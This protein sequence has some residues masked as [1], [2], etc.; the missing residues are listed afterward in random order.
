MDSETLRERLKHHKD[1]VKNLERE[2]KDLKKDK[3][4]DERDV[5]TESKGDDV[6]GYPPSCNEG[7]VE[8]DGKC[9]PVN[10]TD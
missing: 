5:K 10:E 8:K 2:I 9:V 7:Y 1:A 3:K 4:E 6:A